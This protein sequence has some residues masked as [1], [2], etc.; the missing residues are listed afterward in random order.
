MASGWHI[1]LAEAGA[2]DA[3]APYRDGPDLVQTG[4]EYLFHVPPLLHANRLTILY[5]P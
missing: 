1:D 2:Y 4:D 5:K 3:T